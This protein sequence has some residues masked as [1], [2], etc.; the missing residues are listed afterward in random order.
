MKVGILGS[1]DVAKA[2]VKGF[3]RQGHEVMMGTEH[4]EKLGE[5]QNQ[6]PTLK[7]GTFKDAAQFGEIIALCVR[8]LAAE[9][10]VSKV[11]EHLEN[12]IILD[13]TNPIAPEPPEAGVIKFFTD[14]RNSLMERLQ[15]VVPSA[16]FVK[17]FNCVG[18][19]M[20]VNP[21]LGGATPTM[22]ICGNDAGAKTKATE[23]LTLF[24]WET[25]DLGTVEAAR[26]IEPLS[27]L[28]CIPGF[29]E[30]SWN[31]AFKLLK[32]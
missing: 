18:A 25:K 9:E 20:M 12:K 7:V 21:D 10:I 17:V 6:E 15:K 5:I 13:T 31:H 29:T 14:L 2:L 28:W 16:K 23:I 27:I 11:K 1:G 19:S 30:N 26:A 24:G 8:G 4:F 22:F 32:K 3:L